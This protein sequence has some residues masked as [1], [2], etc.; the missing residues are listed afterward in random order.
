MMRNTY[1]H[2]YINKYLIIYTIYALYNIE[3]TFNV[4]GTVTKSLIKSGNRNAMRNIYIF[5]NFNDRQTDRL[6]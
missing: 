6:F 2:I 3:N 4:N 1:I 5:D